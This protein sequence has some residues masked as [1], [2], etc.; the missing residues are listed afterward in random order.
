MDLAIPDS[1]L[2]VLIGASGSGKSTF[3]R[4]HFQT[5]EVVSSD[6]CRAI[7]S[8]DE[9]DQAV[10]P[11]AFRLLRFIVSQRLRRK[12]LTVVDATNVQVRSRCSL[13]RLARKRNIH[14]IAI[15]FDLAEATCLERNTE[16]SERVVPPLII[17][18][19]ISQ[20]QHSLT[21]LKKEGFSAIYTLEGLR[22]IENAVVLRQGCVSTNDLRLG[23]LQKLRRLVASR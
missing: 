11:D 6:G 19:Q 3:A 18:E 7:L 21:S 4:K 9:N 16:R 14:S 8:D 15:V 17:S 12:R 22:E 5:T 2:V 10:T 23:W 1:S 20:L 13:L